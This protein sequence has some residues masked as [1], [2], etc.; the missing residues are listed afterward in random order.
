MRLERRHTITAT[1]IF[2]ASCAT[3]GGGPPSG[4]EEQPDAAGKQAMSDVGGKAHGQIVWSS[5][6]LGNH[7]LFTMGTDGSNVRP[8]T[9]GDNVD[10]FPRFSP[11]GSKIAFESFA[12]NLVAGDTNG[13]ADIFVKDLASGAV[14]RVST[15]AEELLLERQQLLE[16]LLLADDRH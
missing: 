7:D 10:W 5:S 6:R 12:S 3:M 8:I 9:K 13:Q 14:T 4:S 2:A 15:A 16:Q 1:A 11:D